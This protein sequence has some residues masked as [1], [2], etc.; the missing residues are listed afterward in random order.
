[1]IMG[2]IFFVFVL[3][4]PL[5]LNAQSRIGYTYSDVKKEFP[6]LKYVDTLPDGAKTY[7]L[8]TEHANVTYIFNSK[9]ICNATFIFPLT[10]GKLN[11][12]VKLY[13]SNYVIISSKEWKA[14][15]GSGVLD[16][17]LEYLTNKETQVVNPYFYW[18][19]SIN[20]E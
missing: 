13:N 12:Y 18:S 15:I 10:Q 3:M 1:M 2:R 11:E 6:S 19:S 14:Y 9:L 7:S 20:E 4:I 8:A 16:I 5:Q 17:K